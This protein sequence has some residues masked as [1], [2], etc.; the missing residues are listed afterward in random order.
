M[1]TT[2]QRTVRL[3]VS[4]A[5][6]DIA[7]FTFNNN[8]NGRITSGAM[9]ADQAVARADHMEAIQAGLEWVEELRRLREEKARGIRFPFAVEHDI[10]ATEAHLT[11]SVNNARIAT[12]DYDKATDTATVRQRGALTMSV[13][14]FVEFLKA[15][16]DF[17]K[18]VS[19]A[20][21]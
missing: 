2:R 20:V 16:R 5:T 18:L 7:V 9:G 12:V 19:R 6:G 17:W 4:D 8:D 15:H 11:L 3:T 14:E 13:D 21:Q 10:Q 1:S